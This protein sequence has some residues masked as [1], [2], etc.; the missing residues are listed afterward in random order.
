MGA[1]T[2]RDALR[3]FAVL[4]GGAAAGC[5]PARLALRVYDSNFANDADLTDRTLAAFVDTVVP[6][7]QGT[8][9]SLTRAFR[10]PNYPFEPYRAYFAS[11]LCRRADRRRAGTRFHSLSVGERRRVVREGLE[12]D[13][14]TRKL[15]EAAIFLTQIAVYA[16]IY[17]DAA[18]CDAIGFE[19]S[20]HGFPAEDLTF[21]DATSYLPGVLTTDG[22]H[23]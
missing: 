18:G 2:R 13:S 21:S 9:A 23:A 20:N 22:N 1:I 10:D 16:G 8:P 14:I 15:Y 19:G 4:V 11:D 5:T 3:S 12:A 17:D 6:G 7:I